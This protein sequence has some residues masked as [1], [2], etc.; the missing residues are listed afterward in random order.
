MNADERRGALASAPIGAVAARADRRVDR[1]SRPWRAAR[2]RKL[3]GFAH[4][5]DPRDVARI[6]IQHTGVRIDRRAAPLTATIKTREHDRSLAT[7]RR[8]QGTAFQ[9]AES[10]E[11]RRMSRGR[12]VGDVVLGHEL[13]REWR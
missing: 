12:Y 4:R 5:G 11:C 3:R 8:E 9:L 6:H 2:Q 7:R 10:L 13:A 1:A